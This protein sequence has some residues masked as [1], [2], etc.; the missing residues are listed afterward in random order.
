MEAY[1]KG[2]GRVKDTLAENDFSISRYLKL[3]DYIS[4]QL[5]EKGSRILGWSEGNPSVG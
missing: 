3:I 5:P 1:M 4:E 2:H